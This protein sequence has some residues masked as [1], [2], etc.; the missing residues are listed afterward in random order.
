VL[1]N[2]VQM[3][4]GLATATPPGGGLGPFLPMILIVGVFWF[5]IISPQR[6]KDKQR[7]AMLSDLAKG[8]TV[9]TTG[10]I[11]GSI[12]GINDKTVVLKVNDDPITKIEF[13]RG[14]IS[15]VVPK[16][17]KESN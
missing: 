7:R 12:L 8:D 13:V 14:A 5:F 4:S 9:V 3:L 6:K 17:E 2:S 15:Q 11:C 10:G 16:E 1:F